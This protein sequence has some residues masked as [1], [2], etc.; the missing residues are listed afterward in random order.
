AGYAKAAGNYGAAFYPTSLAISKGFDQ[1]VW[2]DSESHQK[3]EEVGTMSIVFRL[4][5]KLVTPKTSDTILDGV[6]RNSVIQ[7]AK[8]L[9]IEVE[10][11]DI[12]ISELISEFKSGNLKEVFG[13][14]T[15]AVIASISSFG[16]KDDKF[17]IKEVENSYANILKTSIVNIQQNLSEDSNGWRHKVSE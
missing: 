16:Y 15:A 4:G 8:D 2:T 3:I 5:D 9:D 7:C 12:T 14:G 10:E 6:T 17:E 13:C 1:I 11:R